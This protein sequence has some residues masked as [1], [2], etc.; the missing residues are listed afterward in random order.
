MDEYFQACYLFY[1]WTHLKQ[2]KKQVSMTRKCHNYRWHG[3]EEAEKNKQ[4]HDL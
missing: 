3:E 2:P 1:N 4:Q